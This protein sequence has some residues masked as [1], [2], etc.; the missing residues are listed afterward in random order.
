M[1][2]K[3]YTRATKTNI[4]S[5]DPV[6][7]GLV[8]YGNIWPINDTLL[9]NNQDDCVNFRY[10]HSKAYQKVSNYKV[11]VRFRYPFGG[12]YKKS[13]NEGTE[14]IFAKLNGYQRIKLAFITKTTYFHKNPVVFIATFANVI[15]GLANIVVAIINMNIQ[16]EIKPIVSNYSSLIQMQ[17][18]PRYSSR[19][20]P[21]NKIGQACFGPI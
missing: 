11:N 12:G 4:F 20:S 2:L 18:Y 9:P 7:E 6:C 13:G 8:E 21:F 1:K 3:F 17:S 10:D 19:C 15:F 16:N 14:E 5:E